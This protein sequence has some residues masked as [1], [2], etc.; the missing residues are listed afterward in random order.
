MNIFKKFISVAVVASTVLGSAYSVGM[1][2]E[3]SSAEM[4][5]YAF[6]IK[7]NKGEEPEPGGEAEFGDAVLMESQG[8]YLL[9]DAAASK[10]SD[11]VVKALN[12]RRVEHLSVYV[13][14]YHPDHFEGIEA[15]VNSGIKIDKLYLPD[16]SIG[17]DWLSPNNGTTENQC[18]KIV[19][20]VDSAGAWTDPD[21]NN[22]VYLKKGSTFSIGDVDAEVIGP[23]GS[24]DQEAF[25]NYF[26]S[27][28]YGERDG[29]YLNNYSL[30]TMFTC[31]KIK[32][33]TTGDIESI[34]FQKNDSS[35]SGYGKKGGVVTKL[36]EEYLVSEYGK[37]LKAD[38]LKM[39]HHGLKSSNSSKFIKTVAPRIAF[40]DNT[41]YQ[42]FVKA[43]GGVKAHKYHTPVENMQKYGFSY[44]TGE[45]EAGFGI[46]VKNNK[47]TAYRDA[48]NNLQLEDTEMLQGWVYVHGIKSVKLSNAD[49][50]AGYKKDYTGKDIYYISKTDD[51]KPKTGIC[52]ITVSGEKRTYCFSAGG[53]METGLF[54]KDNG[55]T[56]SNWRNYGEDGDKS[57]QKYFSKLDSKGRATMAYGF[58]KIDGV[59]FYFIKSTGF[60]YIPTKGDSNSPG[61]QYKLKKLGDYYYLF[62]KG[63][64][65]VY[66]K[67]KSKSVMVKFGKKYRA[68]DKNGRMLTGKKKV[69]GKYYTFDKK[70]GYRK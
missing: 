6:Y 49:K 9:M 68:F 2:A 34:E 26:P 57:K 56:Y 44:M 4:K 43:A 60:R 55:Q 59:Y 69:N 37:A 25:N 11:S 65:S 53:A 50:S 38:I 54:S 63:T 8:K 51:F 16:T 18:R 30:T 27:D 62:K 3:S 19:G 36:E 12:D 14:H 40:A 1:A 28:R 67:G 46:V 45:E 58:K 21:S 61:K 48:D 41:G 66:N 33:L 52:Q 39:A 24:Y 70:T 22:V 13:S 20:W 42:E 32:Y 17:G 29:H 35:Y 64:G 47:I 5:I 7:P 31:G 15:I 10:A 23:V